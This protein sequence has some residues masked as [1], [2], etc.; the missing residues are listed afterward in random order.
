MVPRRALDVGGGNGNRGLNWIALNWPF[1][2]ARHAGVPLLQAEVDRNL[3]DKALA[4]AIDD[5]KLDSNCGAPT[6]R[7]T[8]S[9]T[10]WCWRPAWPDVRTTT[11]RS[12]CGG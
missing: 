5:H 10:P 7:A 8:C 4:R 12:C 1:E 3:Q 9:T 6:S 11:R 2:H